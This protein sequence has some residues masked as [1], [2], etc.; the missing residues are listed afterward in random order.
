MRERERHQVINYVK[1]I[2]YKHFNALNHRLNIS[3]LC[4]ALLLL[5][6]DLNSK[7][8]FFS[9]SQFEFLVWC[10][11]IQNNFWL[12]FRRVWLF[13]EKKNEKSHQFRCIRYYNFDEEFFFFSTK[14]LIVL[15]CACG[16]RAHSCINTL[17]HLLTNKCVFSQCRLCVAYVI[18][19]VICLKTIIY[20]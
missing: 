9:S 1:Y 3:I 12:W 15:N 10:I 14:W 11:Y 5:H 4:I 7:C 19:S 18:S 17:S 8:F 16:A 2:I 20:K 6:S 13:E